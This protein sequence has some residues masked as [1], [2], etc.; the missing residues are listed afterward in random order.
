MVRATLRVSHEAGDA[1]AAT[2]RFDGA[3]SQMRRDVW[4]AEVLESPDARTV[5]IQT[6]G[7]ATITWTA[8]EQGSLVRR[9]SS[10]RSG[11]SWLDVGRGLSFETDG[12][13]LLLVDP[14][15]DGAARRMPLVSQVALSRRGQS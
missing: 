3:V 5:R 4:E 13:V 11:Q 2:T 14:Q 10:E 15:A 1:A 12:P 7:N 6:T 9:V 8:D